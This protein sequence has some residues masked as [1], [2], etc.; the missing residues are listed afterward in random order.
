MIKKIVCFFN[1]PERLFVLVALG[2]GLVFWILH[3]PYYEFDATAHINKS[4]ALAQGQWHSFPSDTLDYEGSPNSPDLWGNYVGNGLIKVRQY[5]IVWPPDGMG[6]FNY[7]R[8]F[9]YKQM[10]KKNANGDFDNTAYVYISPNQAQTYTPIGYIPQ[11]LGIRLARVF[12][13]SALTQYYCGSLF[14]LMAYI[15]CCFFA[16][17][18][19]PF[20]K[21]LAF[22][23]CLIPSFLGFATTLNADGV[24]TALA[25][26]FF[27]LVFHLATAEKLSKR[28]FIG[29]AAVFFLLVGCKPTFLVFG[30]LYFMIPKDVLPFKKKIVYLT[31]VALVPVLFALAYSSFTIPAD[32]YYGENGPTA[33]I[34]YLIGN[35]G[36][37][38]F[39]WFEKFVVHDFPM[40]NSQRG[41][42]WNH[43]V[44]VYQD[45]WIAFIVVL[46]IGSLYMSGRVPHIKK[47]Q[48]ILVILSMF[49]YL[50]MCSASLFLTWGSS[51]HGEYFGGV[52]VKYFNVYLLLIPIF[53]IGN[54]KI[55]QIKEQ[56]FQKICIITP[57]T[58]L[59]I[60]VFQEFV[61]Y[62]VFGL[63]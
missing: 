19:F 46:V 9:P 39:T 56:T 16:I 2:V 49:L 38:I 14:Q 26:L 21:W 60:A 31:P 33:K 47:T 24:T 53:F 15:L 55:I 63:S 13:N 51:G 37:V 61:W 17:K 5:A 12:S 28:L 7:P 22:M 6:Y 59:A 23:V 8:N 57:I 62:G 48:K 34:Q 35:S 54:K 43:H 29:S 1:K 32:L 25:C 52:I 36:R 10:W 27:S 18:V 42:E 45:V 3:P 20:K 41:F 30:L 50:L 4:F 40:L 11:A 58:I 44:A